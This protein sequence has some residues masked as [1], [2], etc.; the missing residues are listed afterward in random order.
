MPKA[1]C[2]MLKVNRYVQNAGRELY[3]IRLFSAQR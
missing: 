2:T 1:K 3:C